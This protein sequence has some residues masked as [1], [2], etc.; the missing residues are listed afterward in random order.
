VQEIDCGGETNFN[1]FVEGQLYAWSYTISTL[2]VARVLGIGSDSPDSPHLRVDVIYSD[3]GGPQLFNGLFDWSTCELIYLE[4]AAGNKIGGATNID[5]FLWG[6]TNYRNN[7]VDASS[8]FLPTLQ[9][10]DV[11]GNTIVNGANVDLDTGALFTVLTFNDTLHLA[12][13][14]GLQRG[15]RVR[16]H[17]QRQ[18]RH[19][20]QRAVP[21]VQRDHVRVQPQQRVQTPRSPSEPRLVAVHQ[22]QPDRRQHVVHDG[23]L[24]RAQV[25]GQS[26][27]RLVAPSLS[28]ATRTRRSRTTSSPT[29]PSL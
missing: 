27:Q 2:G 5:N 26:G 16:R 25:R 9:T 20:G 12:E 28:R 24:D 22:R 8:S 29:R 14:P 1:S 4:D 17:L 11:V 7:L 6:N 21:A 19:V 10:V 13:R 18:R 23:L 3:E 15:R